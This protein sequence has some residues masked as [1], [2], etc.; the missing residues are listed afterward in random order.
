MR[1]TY[2]GLGI[3]FGAGLG[4]IAG[5]LLVDAWWWGMLIGAMLGL[6]VGAIVETTTQARRSGDG[7]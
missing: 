3:V 6:V 2:A 1:G 7:A 4:L 5:L